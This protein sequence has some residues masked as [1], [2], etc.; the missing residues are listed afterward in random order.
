MSE[1]IP[2]CPNFAT[3]ANI[4]LALLQNGDGPAA[5][6]DGEAIVRELGAA[7]D[8]VTSDRDYHGQFIKYEEDGK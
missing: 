6:A 4:A 8:A 1:R 7:L 5:V 3:L 2:I